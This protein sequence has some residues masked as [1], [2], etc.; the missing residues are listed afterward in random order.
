MSQNSQQHSGK[1]F[2]L[3]K[4]LKDLIEVE[5]HQ[6]RGPYSFSVCGFSKDNAILLKCLCRLLVSTDNTKV[7][8][9]L[10]SLLSSLTSKTITRPL[11]KE[12][13]LLTIRK[14]QIVLQLV[15]PLVDH[16][17][18]HIMVKEWK[19]K[20]LG[21]IY[22]CYAY[23]SLGYQY[24]DKHMG[25]ELIQLILDGLGDNHQHIRLAACYL[26]GFVPDDSL[27]HESVRQIAQDPFV[28]SRAKIEGDT[29]IWIFRAILGESELNMTVQ[30]EK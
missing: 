1:T 11:I 15:G 24:A 8:I 26:C 22:R 17:T 14:K 28:L 27:P 4:E 20:E 6:R 2:S 5:K 18:R 25:K 12:Y 9:E 7:E 10:N 29:S 23:E 19:N 21:V 13:R 3:S 16:R 30:T